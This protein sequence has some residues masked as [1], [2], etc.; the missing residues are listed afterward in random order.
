MLI[1]DAPPPPLNAAAWY[2]AARAFAK[3]AL[4]NKARAAVVATLPECMPLDLADELLAMGV[5]P[6]F[7][8]DDALTAFEQ[9][10]LVGRAQDRKEA[11]PAL[12]PTALKQGA[13]RVLKELEAKTLLAGFGLAVPSGK[14]CKATDAVKVAK[15]IGFPVTM[16]VSSDAISH[17]TE[18]GGV[19]LNLRNEDEVAAAA[20]TL[21]KI[22]PEIL[23][24]RMITGAV[25]EL[26][27][28]VMR[29]PQFGLAMVVGAGGI[30]TELLEDST[31]LLL[32]ATRNEIESALA[33]LKCWRLV[34]GFRGKTGDAQAVVTAV[35]AVARFADAHKDSLEE[36]D[37]NPL[38][39]LPKGAVAVD[40]LIRMRT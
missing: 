39:V 32:P 36:L 15:E 14:T 29:D 26:I 17:K 5:T 9:A 1:L 11:L 28:G 23:V 30:L 37:I 22:A 40:A 16:K 35:E 13:S 25:A 19:I 10:A 18:A 24:E 3:G 21:V 8:L 34:S 38:L 12:A 31:A 6:M 7:G 2:V 33:S 20:E 4:A 27:V